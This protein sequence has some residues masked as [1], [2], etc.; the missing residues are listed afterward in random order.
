MRIV[1][2][3][4]LAGSSFRRTGAFPIINSKHWSDS[5]NCRCRRATLTPVSAEPIGK[6]VSRV[7]V[8]GRTGDQADF[9]VAPLD[10]AGTVHDLPVTTTLL[11]GGPTPVICGGSLDR[12]GVDMVDADAVMIGLKKCTSMIC[13]PRT[14]TSGPK[15]E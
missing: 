6:H 12:D 2:A 1:L 7:E 11:S 10:F 3:G 13:L 4:E 14:A 5:M 15:D 8:G 9:Q